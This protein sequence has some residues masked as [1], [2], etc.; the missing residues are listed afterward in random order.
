MD[1]KI[2]LTTAEGKTLLVKEAKAAFVVELKAA[3]GDRIAFGANVMPRVLWARCITLAI[4]A[5]DALGNPDAIVT[6]LD[7]ELGNSSQLGT[8]LV[9]DGVIVREGVEAAATS[10]TSLLAERAKAKAAG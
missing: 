9:K 5:V 10:L 2:N 6:V 3:G 4:A 1:N 7:S 8:Q